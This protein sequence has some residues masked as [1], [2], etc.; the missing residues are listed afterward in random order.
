MEVG[1]NDRWEGEL[2]RDGSL[3][4]EDSMMAHDGVEDAPT[5]AH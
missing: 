1:N 4:A 5:E 2:S 3:Q